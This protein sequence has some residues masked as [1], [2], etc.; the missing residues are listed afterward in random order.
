M[1]DVTYQLKVNE[2]ENKAFM[3]QTLSSSISHNAR[4][5]LTSISMLC[6]LLIRKF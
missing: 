4:T 2:A 1:K 3:V 6:E 5:P